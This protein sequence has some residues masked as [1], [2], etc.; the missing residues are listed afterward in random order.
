MNSYLIISGAIATFILV[1]HSTIGCKQF[2]LPLVKADFDPTARRIM[3]FV[4]HMSTLTLLLPPPILLYAGYTG[5]TGEG[6]SY[7]LTFI[8]IQFVL[9]FAVHFSLVVT[10][11]LPGA[12][13]K[14]FQW[15]LFL[16][17]GGFTWM[18]TPPI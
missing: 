5:L 16:A 17:V 18:G 2:F 15:G 14:L 4:W 8:A 9:L 13:Y 6:M 11:G 1:G 7:L 12:V 10:S 3:E